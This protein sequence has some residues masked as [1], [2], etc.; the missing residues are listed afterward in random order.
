L[1][2]CFV[3]GIWW[4]IYQQPCPYPKLPKGSKYLRIGWKQVW[5]ALKEIRHLLQIFIYLVA[6][7]L[8]ADGL[9]TTGKILH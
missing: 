9:N 6:F 8:L 3:L 2:D 7:F 4:F 5:L 1:V